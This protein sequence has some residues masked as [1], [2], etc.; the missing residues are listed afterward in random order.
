M[1]RSNI[2]NLKG[3]GSV[4][5]VLLLAFGVFAIIG[6]TGILKKSGFVDQATKN[7]WGAIDGMISCG[8]WKACDPGLHPSNRVISYRRL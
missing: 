7:S 4:E 5:F 1:N 3:Q 2:K 8:V 6:A